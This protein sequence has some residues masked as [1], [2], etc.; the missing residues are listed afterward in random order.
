M[1]AERMLNTLIKALTTSPAKAWAC[2]ALLHVFAIGSLAFVSVGKFELDVV[3]FAST[4]ATPITLL[5]TEFESQS[6]NGAS[7]VSVEIQP[8]E[9][10][11]EERRYVQAASDFLRNFGDVQSESLVSSPSL[12]RQL[13]E[14]IPKTETPPPLVLPRRIEHDIP[15]RLSSLVS[16]VPVAETTLP[17]FG[18][19]R[20][21]NYPQ[22]AVANRWEGTVLLRVYLSAGGAVTKVE[23]IDSSGF[24]V[25]DGAA[26]NA[27]KSWTANPAR[28]N[29][30]AVATSIRLP[31]K[32]RLPKRR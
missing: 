2:S 5:L 13:I 10:R 27:V 19:N 21:P 18:D 14:D 20:P 23:V 28:R 15:S 11:I 17:E 25:L 4:K 6:D 8:L 22:N 30:K 29:G 31:V 32:F 1:I 7:D 3:Q 9:A 24:P 12:R 16:S 26:V